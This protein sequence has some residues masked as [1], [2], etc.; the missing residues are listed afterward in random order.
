MGVLEVTWGC[1]RDGLDVAGEH[2]RGRE[3]GKQIKRDELALGGLVSDLWRPL[4][5]DAEPRHKQ[6]NKAVRMA[7]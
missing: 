1:Q 3:A 4:G 6:V 2:L 5:E 7:E